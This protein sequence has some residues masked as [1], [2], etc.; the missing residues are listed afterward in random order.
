MDDVQY[1]GTEVNVSDTLS[2]QLKG[3]SVAITNGQ[4]SQ[5]LL[6]RNFDYQKARSWNPPEEVDNW[7]EIEKASYRV[8]QG[9][10]E[11][12]GVAIRCHDES[13]YMEVVANLEAMVADL[14]RSPL[15]MSRG[16]LNYG[17]MVTDIC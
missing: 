14:D 7:C 8:V 1:C 3:S 11:S 13:L 6:C 5:F 17:V 12:P 9:L 16:L 4:P 15:W 2:S 10:F